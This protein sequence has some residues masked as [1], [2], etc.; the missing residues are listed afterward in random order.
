[1]ASV[2]ALQAI[3]KELNPTYYTDSRLRTL[4]SNDMMHA[5]RELG[6]ED[7]IALI[8][9]TG[10]QTILI[11]KVASEAGVREAISPDEGVGGGGG[12][13]G[14]HQSTHTEGNSDPI[15]IAQA[16]VSGLPAA[17]TGKQAAHANLNALSGATGSP[18]NTKFLRGDW[19]WASLVS[20][21]HALSH[22]Y[23]QTDA[24]TI[25]ILQVQNLGPELTGLS[26]QINSKQDAHA[27]LTSLAAQAAQAYGRAL[28]NLGSD[29]DFR[30]KNGVTGVPNGTKF[31]RDD[32]SWN[33]IVI[34]N[35]TVVA[36][37]AKTAID[38]VDAPNIVTN[39]L[40][41]EMFKVVLG[42]NRTIDNPLNPWVD[43]QKLTYK[44]E[45]DGVGSRTVTWGAAFRFG[46]TFP[47]PG[48]SGGSN[49]TDYVSFK[50]NV[51][52]GLWDCVGVALGFTP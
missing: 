18:D 16:Q 32:W 33:T 47:E 46:T 41:G 1:M 49:N 20:A 6:A 3:L 37:M 23:G 22:G 29:A 25:S 44:L 19:S 21:A 40:L 28:L 11:I 8:G 7:A 39:S 30:A 24:I 36:S 35:N 9:N 2:R 15:A 12:G 38:L 10:G 4:S 51:E 50:W 13:G 43:G 48:L 45:Q 27:N 14:P 5:I 31:L 42:G 34:P 52:N 26:V 17:L